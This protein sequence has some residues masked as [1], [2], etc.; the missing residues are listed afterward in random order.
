LGEVKRE[1][2]EKKTI[3]KENQCE[4]SRDGGGIIF[5][6]PSSISLIPDPCERIVRIIIRVEK[7]DRNSVGLEGINS[8]ST[9]FTQDA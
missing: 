8:T 4:S 9:P 7:L 2:R 3:A 6:L 1:T 5:L